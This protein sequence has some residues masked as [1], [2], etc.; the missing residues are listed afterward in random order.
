M[1]SPSA[2]P[3]L[4]PPV[5]AL[6]EPSFHQP[7]AEDIEVL[8]THISYIVLAGEYGYKIKKPVRFAFLDFSTL[9]QRRFF[10]AEEVRL[11]RALAGDVYQRVAG[12]QPGSDGGYQWC[13]AAD[14]AAEEVVL[15]MRRL[16]RQKM[17]AELLARGEVSREQIEAI[18]DRLVPFYADADAGPETAA[19]GDPDAIGRWMVAD[20]AEMQRFRD[21]VVAA[22]DDDAIQEF[23]LST[24][25]RA[26]PLL[27]RRQ[28]QGRVRDGHGDLHSDNICLASE[29]V[30]IF[31]RIEFNPSFRRRDVAADI[32]F[33]AM[34]LEYRGRADLAE[35]LVRYFA[36]RTGDSE[37]ETLIALFACHRAYIRGKV[38]AL[39]SAGDDVDAEQRAGARASATAHFALAYRLSW[40]YRRCLVVVMGLSGSGKSSLAQALESRTGAGGY[41]SDRIRKQLAGLAPTDRAGSGDEAWLY[42]SELS[43][44]T[45]GVLLQRAGADLAAGRIAI[46]DATFLRREYRDQ[47]RAIAAAQG[48]PVLFVECVCPAAVVETR[49]ERRIADN[50]DPSDADFDV[51]LRQ[52][53]DYQPAAEDDQGDSLVVDTQQPL[54]EQLRLVEGELRRRTAVAGLA[55]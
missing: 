6:C 53:Q 52:Q 27:R 16:P 11:N 40:S 2:C 21:D 47:A 13:D 55:V 43:A 33:L 50:H 7:P 22:A 37:L 32:A 19:A 35:H 8:Q 34:D 12:L 25:R 23:C 14:P 17:L 44:R 48:A 5:A 24:L 1:P 15:V 45:Y 3:E 49:I 46:A 38:D 42:S 36:E 20:F 51:Y 28:Q 39:K 10:S 29:G 31:D 26:A 41:N 9:E 18:A 54:A 30:I 4:P